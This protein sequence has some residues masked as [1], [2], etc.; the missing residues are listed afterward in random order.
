MQISYLGGKNDEDCRFFI[1]IWQLKFIPHAYISF[2]SRSPLY[3][4]KN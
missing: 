1:T 2:S 3:R 4:C